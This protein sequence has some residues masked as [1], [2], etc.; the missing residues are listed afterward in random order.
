MSL[1]TLNCE[2]H[3]PPSPSSKCLCHAAETPYFYLSL[4]SYLVPLAIYRLQNN[5]DVTHLCTS[6]ICTFL[7]IDVRLAVCV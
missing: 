7:N 4:I 2:L 6:Y 5:R 3:Q 1:S